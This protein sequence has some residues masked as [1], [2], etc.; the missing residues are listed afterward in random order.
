MFGRNWV[1]LSA[2]VLAV[3][4]L[5]GCYEST[6]VKVY[7]PGKYQGPKDPLLSQQPAAREAALKKRFE[8]VQ[9]DR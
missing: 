6:E 7:K 8:L 3:A 1:M 2:L 9:L 4:G 5:S